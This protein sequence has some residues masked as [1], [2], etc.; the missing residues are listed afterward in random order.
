MV[1]K[2]RF[3]IP[4]LQPKRD[5]LDSKWDVKEKKKKLAAWFKS[6]TLHSG[7]STYEQETVSLG[8]GVPLHLHK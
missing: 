3:E 8:F 2:E 6:V 4:E 5:K 1:C 7:S